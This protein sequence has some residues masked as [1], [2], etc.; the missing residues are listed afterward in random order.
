MKLDKLNLEKCLPIKPSGW[1]LEK[2]KSFPIKLIP[3][4]QK[5]RDQCIIEMINKL[6]DEFIVKAGPKRQNDWF[7]GWGENYEK[8]CETN[9]PDDLVPKYYNKFKYLRFNSELYKIDDDKAELN[10]VRILIN[11]I[12]D[13]YLKNYS[14]IIELGAGTCHHIYEISKNTDE[15]KNFYALDWSESTTKIANKLK[16]KKFIKSIDSFKFD[17]YNPFW[18]RSIKPP[19]ESK[20]VIYSFAAL[21]Q[22]G[23]EFYK[24]FEFIRTTI[25]PKLVI[26]LEPIAELLPQDDLLANLS[27]RYIF[28]RNYLKGY[29]NFLR[30]QSNAGKIKII[31]ESRMPFGSLFIEGYSLVVWAPT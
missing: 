8:F 14:D 26:H 23:E 24:L 16:E 15:P 12:W 13:I 6:D 29:L 28:K 19:E 3:L 4:S 21:E 9:N 11:Y 27:A 31:H 17:F 10:T 22:I 1:F 30:E 20:S 7:K 5:E 18:E 25:K 2:I